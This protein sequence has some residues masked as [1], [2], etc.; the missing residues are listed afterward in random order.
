MVT[1]PRSATEVA[2]GWRPPLG[3]ARVVASSQ[4]L[5]MVSTLGSPP[6]ATV[7]PLAAAASLS[8]T[9]SW[10][11]PPCTGLGRTFQLRP[12][13]TERH[14]W[15]RHSLP[16]A[17]SRPVLST[18]SDRM[19]RSTAVVRGS[20]LRGS[21]VGTR[22]QPAPSGEVHTAGRAADAVPNASA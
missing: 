3:N 5:R 1:S 17:A 14:T 2:K 9:P 15:G 18:V 21:G 4:R 16:P 12:P 6:M 22:V 7:T 13:S 8:S 19:A 11:R 10:N 20:S